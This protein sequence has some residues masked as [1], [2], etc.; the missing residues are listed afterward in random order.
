MPTVARRSFRRRAGRRIRCHLLEGRS[1]PGVASARALPS[2]GIRFFVRLV[3]K[4]VRSQSQGAERCDSGDIEDN[5]HS[6]PPV[7]ETQARFHAWNRGL[8]RWSNWGRIL[9]PQGNRWSVIF[10]HHLY[11]ALRPF[12]PLSVP[13]FARDESPRLVMPCFVCRLTGAM[14]PARQRSRDILGV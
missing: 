3:R 1:R 2:S 13:A 14:K 8:R 11:R 9:S 12:E 7:D 4:K 5:P 10:Q 6:V